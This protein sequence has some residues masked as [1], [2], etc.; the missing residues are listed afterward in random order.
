MSRRPGWTW[1]VQD[2]HDA[3]GIPRDGSGQ[4]LIRNP[5]RNNEFGTDWEK[6]GNR[7]Y[8]SEETYRTACARLRERR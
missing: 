2:I 3:T 5:L 8:M 7:Y 6:R 1:T 4:Q